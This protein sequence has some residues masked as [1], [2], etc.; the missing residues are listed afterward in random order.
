MSHVIED[1]TLLREAIEGKH[2]AA[3]TVDRVTRDGAAWVQSFGTAP[4][5]DVWRAAVEMSQE[6]REICA[7]GPDPD[8]AL[9]NLR[10]RLVHRARAAAQKAAEDHRKA[11]ADA[12]RTHGARAVKLNEAIAATVPAV[13]KEGA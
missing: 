12:D 5:Y 2:L 3:V 10:D 13:A 9:N 1:I 4:N 6:P 7:I 8:A 11:I